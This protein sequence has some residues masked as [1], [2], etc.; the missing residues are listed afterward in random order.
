MSKIID[1]GYLFLLTDLLLKVNV[2]KLCFYKEN[3]DGPVV[4]RRWSEQR[5]LCC[6][7]RLCCGA[8]AGL[9]R[10]VGRLSLH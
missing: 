6:L 3:E 9:G 1:M 10:G 7:L 2:E 4:S 8:G 5:C